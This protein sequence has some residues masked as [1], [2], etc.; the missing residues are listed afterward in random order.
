MVFSSAGELFS[1]SGRVLAEG[2]QEYIAV[3]EAAPEGAPAGGAAPEG[4]AALP[5]VG[6]RKASRIYPKGLCS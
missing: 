3:P 2:E 1:G 4:D 6:D 5:P